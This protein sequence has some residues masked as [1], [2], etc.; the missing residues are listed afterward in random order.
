MAAS[1]SGSRAARPAAACRALAMNCRSSSGSLR[2]GAAST[3]L[4]TSTPPGRRWVD[5]LR[6]VVGA[7]AA[8]DDEALRGRTTPSA[9]RQSNTWPEPGFC[10][11]T[12][13]K[14]APKSSKRAM[15]R[16][17]AGK[18]LMTVRHAGPHPLRLLGR[19]VPVHLR[20][21]QTGDADGLDDA[22]RRLVPEH[23][24]GQHVLGQ[25]LGD[26]PGQLHRDLARRRGE[27]E[28]D[29]RRAEAHREQRVGLRRDAAD[30]DEQV[31]A[32]RV[33]TG[34]PTSSRSWAGRS[35]A[36]IS[37]SPTRMAS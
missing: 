37:V 16:S 13:R 3:P 32:H 22:L 14:S 1:S 12:R 7:Q 17:P 6:H 33:P 8:R 31:L 23:A 27:H 29:R 15:V 19:L 25:A 4:E 34:C 28:A 2:P 5:G 20:R 35:A 24:D 21:A 9:R 18:A 36:R 11:S 26:V 10:P 30:L